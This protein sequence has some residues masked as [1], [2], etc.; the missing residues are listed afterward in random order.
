MTKKRKR[1][2]YQFGGTMKEYLRQFT[3]PRGK[4]EVEE[5]AP[6]QVMPPQDAQVEINKLL[7]AQRE[8]QR[9]QAE[10]ER[11]LQEKQRKQTAFK[12]GLR[13]ARDG[14]SINGKSLFQQIKKA[15]RKK[16]GHR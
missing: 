16:S 3:T 8:R 4:V 13:T 6:R 11:Q 14:G 2:G 5:V 7:E 15:S 12:Y 10:L 9:A 1:S